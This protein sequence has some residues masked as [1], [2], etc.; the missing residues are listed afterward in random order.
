MSGI[1]EVLKS[2]AWWFTT[3]IV[4]F[5]VSLASGVVR[6]WV[7]KILARTSHKQAIRRKIHLNEFASVVYHL[8]RDQSYQI[9]YSTR[10]IVHSIFGVSL[11]LVI[12][13]FGIYSL[14][15][16]YS[17]IDSR[18]LNL[19]PLLGFFAIFPILMLFAWAAGLYQR[20]KC[21]L[22]LH[23][24]LVRD[25]RIRNVGSVGQV[26]ARVQQR[27]LHAITRQRKG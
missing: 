12:V 23:R 16:D 27:K 5:I 2:P 24:E 10:L 19:W 21:I 15:I 11:L 1:V 8:R 14:T 3:I 13:A 25:V 4:G 20:L 9:S 7:P 17:K 22:R 26:R 18:I 6:D